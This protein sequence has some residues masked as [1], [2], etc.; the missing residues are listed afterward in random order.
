MHLPL[1]FAEVLNSTTNVLNLLCLHST[2]IIIIVV[3]TDNL[4]IMITNISMIML[5]VKNFLLEVSKSN[6]SISCLSFQ[7]KNFFLMF[8]LGNIVF[9]CLRSS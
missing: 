3:M 5:L 4:A 7:I 2:Y 6:S 9:W 1:L 8:I